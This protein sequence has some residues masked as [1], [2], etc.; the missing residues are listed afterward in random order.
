MPE[1]QNVPHRHVRSMLGEQPL[2]R[3]ASGP[4]T[5][6]AADLE[7]RCAARGDVAPQDYVFRHGPARLSLL[8]VWHSK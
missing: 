6:P 4:V 1:S 7:Q 5:P 2:H 8:R 3:E